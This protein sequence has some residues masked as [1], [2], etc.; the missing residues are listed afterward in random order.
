MDDLR[1]VDDIDLLEENIDDIQ[2]SLH[3]TV[4]AAS[5]MDLVVNIA[6]TNRVTFS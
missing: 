4:K 1:F 3:K 6:K 2:Q 5:E